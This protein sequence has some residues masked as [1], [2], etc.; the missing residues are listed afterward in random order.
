M[1]SAKVPIFPFGAKVLSLNVAEILHGCRFFSEVEDEAFQRL[2]SIARIVKFDRGTLIFYENQECP[3]VYIVGTGLVRVFKTAATGKE[4][5]LHIVGPGDTFAEVDAIGNF[6]VPANAEAAG[7]E[8]IAGLIVSSMLR[9]RTYE[10]LYPHGLEL[11]SESVLHRTREAAIA[12]NDRGVRDFGW[13]G[14]I[15]V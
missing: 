4:H 3:G 7:E 15:S 8:P 11:N 6:N 5:V 12:W 9:N 1:G 14:K 2:L 10:V 13:W